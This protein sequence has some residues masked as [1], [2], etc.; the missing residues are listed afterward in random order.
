[1]DLEHIQVFFE[2][3]QI[4]LYLLVP[5]DG[6]GHLNQGLVDKVLRNAEFQILFI[7]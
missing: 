1:M 6:Y 4:Y 2:R 5:P 7:E 3:I